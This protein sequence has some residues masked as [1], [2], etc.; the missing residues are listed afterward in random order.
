MLPVSPLRTITYQTTNLQ[1][2]MQI[3]QGETT[4]LNVLYMF[5]NVPVK[6]ITLWHRILM[7]VGSVQNSYFCVNMN[8]GRYF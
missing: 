2:N 8:P 5:K 3:Q 6:N 4:L 1:T 7:V